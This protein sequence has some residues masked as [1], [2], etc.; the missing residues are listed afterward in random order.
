M[1]ADFRCFQSSIDRQTPHTRCNFKLYDCIRSS[2]DL[3]KN[4][5]RISGIIENLER[6]IKLNPLLYFTQIK[7][8]L[9]ILNSC[10][11]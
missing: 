10:I 7:K 2:P 11:F 1:V 5:W 3:V 9:I 6:E 4:E 8:M